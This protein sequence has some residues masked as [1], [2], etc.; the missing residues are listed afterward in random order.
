[1]NFLIFLREKMYKYMSTLGKTCLTLFL[2]QRHDQTR[3]N[4][5]RDIYK[6]QWYDPSLRQIYCFARKLRI[7]TTV[8]TFIKFMSVKV[9]FYLCVLTFLLWICCSKAYSVDVDLN[10]SVKV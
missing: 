7:K 1:M 2:A 8:Y 9:V 10:Y 3:Q 6:R 5:S 4:I